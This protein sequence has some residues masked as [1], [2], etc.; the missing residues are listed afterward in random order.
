MTSVATKPD[1]PAT[2]SF[3]ACLLLVAFLEVVEKEP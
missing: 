1:A 3:M 2:I